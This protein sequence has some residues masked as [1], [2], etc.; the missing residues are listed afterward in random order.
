[1]Q[2][3]DTKNLSNSDIENLE[4]FLNEDWNDYKD[5]TLGRFAT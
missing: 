5:N 3:T 2:Y 4:E 1:M